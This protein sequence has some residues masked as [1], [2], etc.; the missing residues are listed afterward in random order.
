MQ[1]IENPV[2]NSVCYHH[3]LRNFKT[4]FRTMA[5]YFVVGFSLVF[6]QGVNTVGTQWLELKSHIFFYSQSVTIFPLY[7]GKLGKLILDLS[8]PISRS[9]WSLKIIFFY[10]WILEMSLLYTRYKVG[11]S[12]CILKT[13]NLPIDIKTEKFENKGIK[14]YNNNLILKEIK[15][16][17]CTFFVKIFY[18]KLLNIYH[19]K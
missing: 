13:L 10:S 6:K 2:L 5:L 9:F 18:Q 12:M 4:A 17:C 16:R 14:R 8:S 1:Y 3:C 7:N 19:C 15:I 11:F